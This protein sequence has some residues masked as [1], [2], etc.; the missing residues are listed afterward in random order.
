VIAQSRKSPPA[1]SND[2]SR[3]LLDIVAKVAI[4]LHPRRPPIEITLDSRLDRECGLDSLG[5]VELIARLERAFQVTLSEHL[6]LSV[7]TPRDLLR[8]LSA[9]HPA[10][11]LNVQEVAVVPAG[12]GV[13]PSATSTLLAALDWHVQGHAD[14]PHLYLHE[15]SGEEKTLSY[16]DLQRGAQAVAAGL[17]AHDLRLGQ[18]V[19]IMLPTSLDYFFSFFGVLQA[20]GIPVPVY[21]PARASQIEE[22]LRRHAR[23]L[24]NA[25]ATILITVPE[26]K[27]LA[28]LLRLQVEGLHSVTTVAELAASGAKVKPVAGM[29]SQDI[30][31]LQYTSGST[32]NPKGVVLTHANLLANIRAMGQTIQAGSEDVFVSWMP[33]YHDMGLIGAWLGSLYYGLPLVV[34]SPLTFLVRPERWLWAIHRH[35][36]TLSGSPNFGY[37]L[38]LRRIADAD[39]EGLDLS[40]WRLAFN[41]AEKVSPDTITRFQERFARYGFRPQTMAPVYG[42][43]E[44]SVGLAFPPLGRAPLIDR[45]DRAALLD[46]GQAQP[47]APDDP[48][49]L[50]FVGCGQPLPGHQIRIVDD[51]GHEVGDREEGRLEFRGPSTTSG[52]FRNPEQ[53]QRLFHDGWLDSGD[54]AYTVAGEAFLTGRVKDII[55]RAGRNLH[56]EELEEAIGNLPGARKGCVAVFGGSDPVSGTET[57]VVLAET[58][59]TDSAT[60][61][62]LRAAIGALAM[63]LTGIAPDDIVL[64]PPH[65]VLKTSSGKIRRAA[66]RELYERNQIGAPTRALW[67][68]VLH[69]LWAGVRPVVRRSARAASTHLYALYA[70]LL[71]LIVAPAVWLLTAPLPRLSWAWAV[72]HAAARAMMRLSGTPLSVEG[73]ELL[74]P[75]PCVLVA[76]HASYLDSIVLAAALAKPFVFVAKGELQSQFV[77][78]VYLKRVGAVFVERFDPARGS[79]DARRLAELA[80]AGSRLAFFPEGTFERMSGLAPFHMGAFVA[81]AEAGV[82]VVPL[83]IRGTRGMLR[84][85]QWFPRRGAIRVTVGKPLPPQGADWAAALA[86]RDAARAEILHH[87]GEPDLSHLPSP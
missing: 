66:S 40:S 36:A 72:S 41:G 45:V 56:P 70:W 74:P 4:E 78:R 9:A 68:Q 85:D 44:S 22:H 29:Q 12:V 14:R 11:P 62:Q 81:A 18:T 15:E 61:E 42:L 69:L 21:P 37:E 52:Y 83:A 34:M 33:L 3:A 67:R 23:I 54:L 8:A 13:P 55:I 65:T 39:I 28:Q 50:R 49:A 46:K 16:A 86:L 87:C 20:G 19:A 75:G 27:S 47:A 51:T 48:K 82:P 24:A 60:H 17:Q 53:T 59:T 1:T 30:A 31:M 6:L 10:L 57:L 26:A 2:H 25:Q 32:G 63:D 5:R 43:A 64:A 79:A 71:F 7:E 73:L 76:N 38:C 35:R 80:R 77:P 84:P 58:R